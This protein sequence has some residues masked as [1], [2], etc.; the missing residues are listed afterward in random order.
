MAEEPR[1]THRVVRLPAV[2][3]DQVLAA[4]DAVIVDLRSPSEFALDHIPG[5]INLPL[6]DDGQRAL[7][8]TLYRRESP[9]AAFQKGREIVRDHVREL[10]G[11]IAR[12]AGWTLSSEDLEARVLEMTAGG[13][14]G[15][16]ACVEC[17][18]AA[19][20]PLRPVVLH[21]WRGGLRS[22][23]VTA[24][25][26]EIGLE[27]AGVL[28]GGYKS[29]RA[30][31]VRELEGIALPRAVVLRGLTG[32][33]KTLV[34]R[35]IARAHP[36]WTLDLE[37]LAGHRSSLLGSV[38]LEPC[39]QKMFE[40]RLVARLR[41][42]FPNFFVVEGESRRVGDILLHERLWAAIAGGVDLELATGV[43]RRIEV[44]VEDY[45]RDESSREQLMRLLPAIEERM[46]RKAGAESLTAMLARG[47][48]DDLVRLLLDRYYDPLYRHSQ[49][50]KVYAARFDATDPI[51]AAAEISAWIETWSSSLE[52]GRQAPIRLEA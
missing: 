19:V 4:P 12:H 49:R 27:R 16:I 31:I 17:K 37:A 36:D 34:L 30:S 26:L 3:I 44:L 22:Q 23:S 38:G 6:F 13:I 21:C 52:N 2:S 25:M 10:A 39:S 46:V 50:E 24:L 32:V 8:G 20:M 1:E 29:Y 43:E 47:A 9:A 48:V 41:R 40:S 15:L 11:G 42:G 5:A 18:P 33:G 45:L 35:E 14:D 51:R 28:Q 7:V